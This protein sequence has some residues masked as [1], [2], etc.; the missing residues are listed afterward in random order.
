MKTVRTARLAIVALLLVLTGVVLLGL[1]MHK[2]VTLVLNGQEVPRSTYALTVGQF[3]SEEKILLG[4]E[5]QI[6]PATGGWLREGEIVSIERAGR[7]FIQA[8]GK[9]H[10]LLTTERSPANL[11]AAAGIPLYPGDRLL[12]D[13]RPAAPDQ[14][15]SPTSAHSLQVQRTVPIRLSTPTG[16]V[17]LNSSA[18]TL[19]QALWEAGIRLWA[20]DALTPAPETPLS[21]PLEATLK[22]SQPLVVRFQGGQIR[23]RSAAANTGDALAAAGLPLQGLDYSIP[24]ASDPLPPDGRIRIVRVQESVLLETEP[25]SFETQSQPLPDLEIDNQEIVEPGAY[26][27]AARRI[28]VRLEDGV[29]VSRQVEAEYIAQEPR[30]RI[31]GYGTKIVQHSLDISGG[32]LQYW[33]ALN[34]YA[35]SYNPTS[36]GGTITA[37][38]LPLAKG[39]AAVDPNYIPLGTRLFIPGYGEAI[40]ADTGGGV[41]GRMIDLGYSDADYVSWHQWVTVY[42]LWPPPANVAWIIP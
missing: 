20:M 7:V 11:L 15:L 2:T 38:G 21:G 3:L 30:P 22:T 13:G 19:G 35:V 1:W 18:A 36:A 25:L 16:I 24:P 9:N 10:S 12:V 14:A 23:L 41:Q 29:E 33:R 4:A 40:A 34:M 42:F 27:L 31:L 17:N 26:G 32:S 8:D 6:L 39:V 28:R 5:D 37:S